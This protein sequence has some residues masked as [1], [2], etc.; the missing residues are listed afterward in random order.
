MK[1]G[2]SIAAKI[3]ESLGARLDEVRQET[4]AL[5][6]DQYYPRPKKR[7]QPPVLDEFARDLTQLGRESKLD[8]VIGREQEIERVIQ[9]LAR[10]TK[11]NPVLTGEPGVGKTA[12][13]EGLAQKI[14]SHDVPDVLGNKRLV[15]LD[16]GA[17]GAGTEEPGQFY[18]PLT[19]VMKEVCQ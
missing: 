5:L 14:V 10:R 2:Q 1:E 6:G 19:A 18:E 4:L 3:L 12:I 17:L 7:S 16:L 15:Q 13:V 11:N 9:I 8:P